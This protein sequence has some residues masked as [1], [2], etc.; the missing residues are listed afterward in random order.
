MFFYI[1]KLSGYF[2]ENRQQSNTRAGQK[3]HT[4]FGNAL[5]KSNVCAHLKQRQNIVA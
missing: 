4:F 1:L 2:F 3:K 5:P